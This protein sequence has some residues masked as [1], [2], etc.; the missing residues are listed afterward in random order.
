MVEPGT[1]SG[2]L[3]VPGDASKRRDSSKCI[4]KVQTTEYLVGKQKP[5]TVL[6]TDIKIFVLPSAVHRGKTRYKVKARMGALF[7]LAS[8]KNFAG[9]QP[10]T[11][12]R[13]QGRLCRRLISEWLV[14]PC[15]EWL[16]IGRY[17][18]LM[19]KRG[20]RVWRLRGQRVAGLPALQLP[21]RLFSLSLPCIADG[22]AILINRNTNL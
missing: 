11:S 13:A 4:E 14:A 8:C 20:A 1:K 7:G 22:G 18:W 5:L 16:L 19:K 17:R 9:D 21:A 2:T 15:L 12:R 10:L 6:Y 3:Q